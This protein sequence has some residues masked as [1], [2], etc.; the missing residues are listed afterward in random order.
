[1][2]RRS[3]TMRSHKIRL[4]LHGDKHLS[5]VLQQFRHGLEAKGEYDKAIITLR[6][7]E[8]DLK[9]HGD[10]HPSTGIT[11]NNLGLV[12]SDRRI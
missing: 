6:V 2:T 10:K 1:M 3:N 4:E 7:T 8:I 12:W 5:K 9:V 11:Y